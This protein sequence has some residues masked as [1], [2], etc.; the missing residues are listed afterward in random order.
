MM[1][2]TKQVVIFR[3]DLKVHKGKIGSQVAHASLGAVKSLMTLRDNPKSMSI[4][5]YE[6]AVERI[7]AMGEW[8][9]LD[10]TTIVLGTSKDSTDHFQELLDLQTAARAKGLPTYLV[11]DNGTTE[12]GGVKT[13]TCLAIGPDY[14]EEFIGLTDHLSPL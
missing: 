4:D 11:T 9:N 1:A 7:S 2:T 5:Y 10:E 13:I 8:W 14:T 12:F 6:L 3:R